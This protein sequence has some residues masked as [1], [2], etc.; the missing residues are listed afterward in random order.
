MA[1]NTAHGAYDKLVILNG[2]TDYH[3]FV[4]PVSTP[5]IPT[6]AEY[7]S[8][9]YIRHFCVNRVDKR[10]VEIDASQYTNL[11]DKKKGIDPFHW[12]KIAIPWKLK[13][14]RFDEVKDGIFVKKGVYHVNKGKVDK[15]AKKW[16]SINSVITDY[17]LYAT[18][19]DASITPTS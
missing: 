8:G 16:P 4:S 7:K 17:T 19:D 1:R 3:K 5:S 18:L 14:P 11:P 12:E 6:S 13:G 9:K 15:I 10:I 2:L